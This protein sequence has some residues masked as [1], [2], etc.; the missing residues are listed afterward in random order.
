MINN[1]NNTIHCK[2]AFN[3]QNRRFSFYGTEFTQ[4]R[5][6]V[7]QLIG[8]PVNG[9]VL[10]YVD[11]ESD[12]ITVSSNEEFAIALA[13]SEKVL[14]LKA[15]TIT[16]SPSTSLVEDCAGGNHHHKMQ[17]HHGHHGHR[18]HGCHDHQ[19][20]HDNQGHHGHYGHHGH[21]GNHGNHGHHGK[22]GQHGHGRNHNKGDRS[23]SK[24]DRKEKKMELLKLFLSQMPPDE[25]LTPAQASRK[26]HLRQKIQKLESRRAHWSEKEEICKRRRWEKKCKRDHQKSQHLSPEAHQQVHQLKLQIL[27]LRPQLCQLRISKKQKKFELRNF[28]QTGCGDKDA[29]WQEILDLKTKMTQ[30]KSQIQPLKQSVKDLKSS[31]KQQ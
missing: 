16:S 18:N 29:I 28:L 21:H 2:L 19:G 15:D 14:R 3:G 10:K 31:V 1:N 5:E 11:N 13:I 20:H 24:C 6:Q 8:L 12:L 9:F 4:L 27:T 26:E 7:S 23:I 22:H 30:M 25:S 17:N